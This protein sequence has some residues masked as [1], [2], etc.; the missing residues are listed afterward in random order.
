MLPVYLKG[1]H[2]FLLGPRQLGF[3]FLNTVL[4]AP[5]FFCARLRAGF[6]AIETLLSL[7]DRTQLDRLLANVE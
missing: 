6:S 2:C 4:A 7:N 3:R 1:F 5:V